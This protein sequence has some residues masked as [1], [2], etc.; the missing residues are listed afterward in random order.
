M[1]TGERSGSWGGAGHDINAVATVSTPKRL[2]AR[3]RLPFRPV[4]RRMGGVYERF[5]R[6]VGTRGAVSVRRI[7][8]KSLRLCR[9]A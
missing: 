2:T 3:F 4:R 7:P 6:P 8:E 1:S 9:I 5:D